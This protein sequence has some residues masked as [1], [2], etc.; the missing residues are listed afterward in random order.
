ML[1]RSLSRSERNIAMR[2][3]CTRISLDLQRRISE[4]RYRL[5]QIR[6]RLDISVENL[7][8]KCLA[9]IFEQSAMPSSFAVGVNPME[10]VGE[11]G[12]WA[13]MVIA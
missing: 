4:T 5:E 12:K 7:F 2:V 9:I 1:E 10:Q 8:V 11:H 13:N 6:P 3:N